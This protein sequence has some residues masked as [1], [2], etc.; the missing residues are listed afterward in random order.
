MLLWNEI[1]NSQQIFL[2][3]PNLKGVSQDVKIYSIIS[4]GLAKSVPIGENQ[5][6]KKQKMNWNMYSITGAVLGVI[7]LLFWINVSILSTGVASENEI[8]SLV[9]LPFENRGDSK[10]DFYV[11]GISSDLISDITSVGQFHY[12]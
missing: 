1:L 4:H 10:E 11:Y 2:G 8:P 7:G 9:I 3:S 6:Q 12:F 5:S